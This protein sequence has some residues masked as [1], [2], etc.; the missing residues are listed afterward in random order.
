MEPGLA[1]AAVT[2]LGILAG[3][4]TGWQVRKKVAAETE[5][6]RAEAEKALAERDNVSVETATS[7][8]QLANTQM[9]SLR[10][11]QDQLR[12]T[13]EAY[14]KEVEKATAAEV[15]LRSELAQVKRRVAV[16]EEYISN[17]GLPLPQ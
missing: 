14:R 13:V 12:L 7:A 3:V 1:S 2:A 9:A 16:L 10:V 6:T 8:V 4:W 17:A 15:K 5:K 11:E